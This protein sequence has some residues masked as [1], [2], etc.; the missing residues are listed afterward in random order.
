MGKSL[1]APDPTKAGKS[2][3][4]DWVME[5]FEAAKNAVY[6]APIGAGAGPFTITA[7]YT[8]AA[9]TLAMQRVALAGVRLANLLN[10]E[11]K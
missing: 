1:P 6:V 10:T 5:S 4:A 9:R 3:A 7:V 11:L 8:D 2:D